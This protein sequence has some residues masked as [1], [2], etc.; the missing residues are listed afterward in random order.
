MTDPA[1]LD[2]LTRL[3][4]AVASAIERLRDVGL[5]EGCTALEPCMGLDPDA[6]ERVAAD[7][8]H[9]LAHLPAD[10]ATRLRPIETLTAEHGNVLL[11]WHDGKWCAE[12]GPIA[13]VE[14]LAPS[15]WTPLPRV[16]VEE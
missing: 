15:H 9:A 4:R 11:W 13:L 14:Q 1:E 3:R 6:I 5:V 7:L 16:R 2:E 8:E 10:P 12:V